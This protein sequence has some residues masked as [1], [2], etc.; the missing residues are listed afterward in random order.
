MNFFSNYFVKYLL[1]NYFHFTKGM[2]LVGIFFKNVP[3][4]SIVGKS[5][6][7]QTSSILRNISFCVILCRAGLSLDMNS[8]FK[9][10][11]KIIKFSFIPCLIETLA[12]GIIGKFILNIPFSWAFLL[13]YVY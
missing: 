10:K 4:L 13:G 11:W 7:S 3:V 5:I 2:L 9:L 6:D 12:F 1:I 8:L